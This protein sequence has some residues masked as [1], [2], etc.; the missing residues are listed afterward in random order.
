MH[1]HWPHSPWAER[2]MLIPARP[3]GS[4]GVQFMVRAEPGRVDELYTALE[5]T[6]LR[7]D[8]R[9]IV[10]VRTLKEIKAKTY[11]A[12][13]VVSQLL[14][15]LSFLLVL[16]T[17]LGIIGLTSFS[18]TQRTREIGTRRALGATR[19]AILRYFLVENWLVTSVGLAL[20]LALT[21]GLS[22]A[23][24]ESA[25]VMRMSWTNVA[26]SMLMLWVA[27]LLAAL[28]PAL[29]GT[30]VPPVIATRTV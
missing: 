28:I 19:G 21:Y 25:E 2:L 30:A 3:Y 23:L 24:A 27:G 26:T 16:V 13:R 9:R 8:D 12:N 11:R 22:F 5:A 10:G 1:N 20:G 14:G 17:S 4:R 6:L 7:V 15:V 29:R 18:V